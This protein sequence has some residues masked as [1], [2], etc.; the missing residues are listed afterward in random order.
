MD[1]E[2]S[3]YLEHIGTPRHSGRY[4]WGSG[5]NPYQ[6]NVGFLG[7]VADLRKQGLSDVDI[8]KGLGLANTSELRAK[9]SV[10]KSEKRKYILAEST[11]LRDKGWSYPAIG[12]KLGVGES[13]I[14]ATMKAADKI[15]EDQVIAT[16]NTLRDQLKSKTYLDVGAGNE[17]FLGISETKF[18]TALAVLKDEGYVVESIEVPQVGNPGSYTTL[19]VLAPPGSTRS[20]INKN[21]DKIEIMQAYSDDGGL[22]QYG[23]EPPKSISSK[24]LAIRYAEDGGTDM[25]GVIEIRRGVPDISLGQARYAQVR[26][27]V[28]DTHFLKGMA[29]YADDLPPGVDMR[30]NTNKSATGNKLDALKTMKED[31][32]NPFGASIKRQQHYIDKDG[33]S[34][35]SPINIV[36][37]EGDWNAWGRNLSSQM[38]SK[39]SVPL[40]QKQLEIAYKKRL[41]DFEEINSLTNPV[42]KKKLMEAYA[43]S[44]D[45]AAVHLKAAALPRQRTQVILPIKDLKETEIYAPNFRDGERVVLIRYPHGGIFEI[46]ELTVNNKNPTGRRL[47]DRA[48]DAV[49]INSK[50]AEKLSG[51]DFDGD[52][53]LVIPDNGRVKIA[54]TLT[55]LKGFD[56]KTRY[57]PYDGM[58]TM[59]G[60]VYNAK[61]RRI[62]VPDGKRISDRETGL[63]MGK[64]SNLI[65]DMTIRKAPASDI[66]RAVKHSMVVIDAE[67]HGLNYKQSEIDNGIKQLKLRYQGQTA[68]GQP[69]GASTLISR[70]SAETRVPDRK[71]RSYA[72]GGP[73]DKNTGELVYEYSGK[74]YTKTL[75]NGEQRFVPSMTKSKG[76]A[77]VSDARKLSSGTPMEEV[78]ATHANRLKALANQARKIAVNSEPI[79]YSPSA[80]K[81]YATEVSSLRAKL[82][83]ARKN[84]PLERKAQLV[85]NTIVA[86]KVAANPEMINSDLKKIKGQALVTARQRFGSARDESRVQITDNEWAA[87]QAGAVSNNTLTE[88]LSM[89]DLD[90]V[91]ELAMPRTTEGL[92]TSRKARATAMYDAGRTQ[93]E[94]ADALGVSVSTIQKELSGEA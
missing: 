47:L 62:E 66:A 12:E 5:E 18:K 81:Q 10:A 28:D 14:R 94:I 82:N 21:R 19:R 60:G 54:P 3:D 48:Q 1:S 86:A 83:V 92:A 8:A 42:V 58:R 23:I 36:N 45:S 93:S 89:T 75:K 22:T 6:N 39:Q 13:T 64:V 50:V 77:D 69:A 46:P 67:K 16:A 80:R 84:K 49:G 15:T 30:F 2:E 78:Y 34:K 31:P 79:K 90:R 68:S 26:I 74:G 11:K 40:A 7:Y 35:L 88:I 91:R 59:G 37:E 55:E 41:A 61:T 24:R 87:I 65:T 38:L 85:A 63:E 9:L 20:E 72:K 52:T 17:N 32:D 44:T 33:K 53:V 71:L 57:P 27:G 73:V 56:P 51:A 43:D 70:A 25:D 29:I 76:M 4:P